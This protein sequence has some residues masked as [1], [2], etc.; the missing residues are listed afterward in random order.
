MYRVLD[1]AA[2]AASLVLGDTTGIVSQA[3][4]EDEDACSA[5]QGTGLTQ[6]LRHRSVRRVL[7]GGLATDYCVLNTVRDALEEDFDVL[8]LTDA[9]RAVDMHPGE[10]DAAIAS[11]LSSGAV[12]VT[13]DQ[14][15]RT[16]AA[17]VA[18]PSRP[19]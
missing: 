18:P 6:S 15:A 3:G 9:L 14:L 8:L 7:V 13:L 16:D 5:F 19:A 10:G 17:A 1:G 4:R 11:M 12:P 2:S